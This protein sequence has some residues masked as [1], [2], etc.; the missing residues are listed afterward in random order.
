ML[1]H[2]S[3][4][5]LLKE[6]R[7]SDPSVAVIVISALSSKEDVVNRADLGIQGYFVK[8]INITELND[9]ILD[10]YGKTDG[11]KAK[12]ASIFRQR[13]AD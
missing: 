6:I 9:R 10:C 12:V 4:Y 8:P 13:L 5:M 7:G 3:G 11:E 2:K 1:P